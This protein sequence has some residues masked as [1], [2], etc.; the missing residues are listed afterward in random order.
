[1]HSESNGAGNVTAPLAAD[2][3]S[4]GRG[5]GWYKRD[6]VIKPEWAGKSCF[7]VFDGAMETTRVWVNGEEAVASSPTAFSNAMLRARESA[8]AD[9]INAERRKK[10]EPLKM[11]PYRMVGYEVSGYDSFSF[12]ITKLVKP[13]TN[14]LAVKVV[15]MS[16]AK[17]P[18]DGRKMDYILFGGLYRDVH[19]VVTDPVHIPFA[20][21]ARK[22]GVRVTTRIPEK[23]WWRRLFPGS[24]PPATATEKALVDVETAV[25]ND[26]QDERECRLVTEV[27]DKAGNLVARKESKANIPAGQ[28][29]TFS[30]SNLVVKTPRLWSPDDPYLYHVESIV[31]DGQRSHERAI[32][33]T[34]QLDRVTTRFGVRTYSFDK[35]QGFILNGKPVKLIGVNRHQTWPFIGNAVP[36]GLQR[37]DAEQ[38]KETGFN[39]VRL[40]HYPQSPAFL[41][42]LDELG[43]MALAEAPTWWD[44]GNEEWMANL[45]TSFRS[46][47]RRDRN[48]PCII[49]WNASINHNPAEPRLVQAAKEE[50]PSRP[51]GQDDVACV[52]SFKPDE[53]AANG[54]LTIEYGG[55]T[56][57][58]S[59]GDRDLRS[60]PRQQWEFPQTS[61]NRE[62]DQARMHWEKVDL[63]YRHPDNAGLAA[64]CMYDYN[65]FHNSLNGIARHGLFDIFRLPKEAAWWYRSE[66]TTNPV[67]HIVRI[68]ATNV[69]VFSNCE[70]VRLSEDGGTGLHP[71]A[72]QKPAPGFALHHPPFHFHIS[73][74]SAVL[75]AEGIT[76]G[77]VRTTC[78]WRKPGPPVSLRLETDRPI[79]VADGSDISRV[80]VSVVDASGAPV[81]DCPL[82]VIFTLRGQ[83]RLIGENPAHLRAGKMMILVQA[84][85]ESGE[86]K[87]TA[88]AEGMKSGETIVASRPSPPAAIRRANLAHN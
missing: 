71:V 85:L 76:G 21:E 65:T 59:R 87:I 88:L 52:M 12:E 31:I 51:R 36:D 24:S 33:D 53:V 67:V 27:L 14:S 9:V 46:M 15:N 64:W 5:V 74:G 84:G 29:F 20:W 23:S 66:L 82:P 7:L 54:G 11:T 44:K 45:E 38:I 47:I 78:D 2:Y 70:E 26:G 6:L 19:L 77:R 57:P 35:K 63:A 60:A 42:A 30:Q 81:D 49:I 17:T 68:D 48:H 61:A 10:H 28:S 4:H 39:F 16:N 43:I 34:S 18:P 40:S 37:R 22:S 32:N 56:F 58:T 75:R 62:Y 1:M 8:E 55:H 72:S 3:L 79:I 69:C 83:G 25:R 86:L 50:D 13:G 41:D 80:T 73:S